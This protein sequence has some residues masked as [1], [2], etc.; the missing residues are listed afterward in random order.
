MRAM[1]QCIGGPCIDHIPLYDDN[2][3]EEGTLTSRCVASS[4]KRTKSESDFQSSKKKTTKASFGY[5]VSDVLTTYVQTEEEKILE[6]IKKK[7]KTNLKQKREQSKS[8]EA[9][10]DE[11]L[12]KHEKKQTENKNEDNRNQNGH[13]NEGSKNAKTTALPSIS[14]VVPAKAY[15]NYNKLFPELG[16]SVP[17][18]AYAK[19]AAS[20]KVPDVS[21]KL[22]GADSSVIGIEI[23]TVKKKMSK[24]ERRKAKER[25]ESTKEVELQPIDVK[26]PESPNAW[27]VPLK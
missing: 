13:K 14:P 20:K 27:G 21:R 16:A 15:V 8:R 19:A 2:P 5:L 10:K 1:P 12:E 11:K 24:K 23:V 6:S 18:K 4:S 22:S 26:T 25:R 17:S 7:Q 3:V 9:K